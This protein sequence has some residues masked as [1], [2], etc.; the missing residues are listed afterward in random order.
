MRRAWTVFLFLALSL[1]V[2]VGPAFAEHEVNHRYTLEGSL[3]DPDGNPWKGALVTLTHHLEPEE[4]EVRVTVDS[5]GEWSSIFHL[6]DENLGDKILIS[7]PS[8]GIEIEHFITF[9][10]TDLVN[11]RISVEDLISEVDAI[12][13]VRPSG[14]AIP[15]L[16]TFIVLLAVAGAGAIIYSLERRS[17]TRN[18]A[19]PST[20]RI[21]SKRRR[22]GLKR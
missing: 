22:R 10:P 17:E 18:P 13:V 15:Y 5:D 19:D 2:Q 7:I 3:T 21:K 9:D 1:M 8:A 20:P 12:E 11:E 14:S 16:I 4:T 6:H